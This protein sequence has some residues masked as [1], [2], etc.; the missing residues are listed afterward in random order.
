MFVNNKSLQYRDLI[1]G[2]THYVYFVSNGV[3]TPDSSIVYD[4]V[5]LYYILLLYYG[6]YNAL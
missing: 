4:L 2:L 5:L 6:Y 1:Q 3:F